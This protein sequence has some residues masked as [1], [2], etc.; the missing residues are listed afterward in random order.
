MSM[1]IAIKHNGNIYFGADSQRVMSRMKTYNFNESNYNVWKNEN[2]ENGLIASVGQKRDRDIVYTSNV[3]PEKITELTHK[4]VVRVFT[5]NIINELIEFKRIKPDDGIEMKSRFMIAQKDKL[6][7]VDFDG[8]VV[9]IDDFYAISDADEVAMGSLHTTV[10]QE[11]NE[12]IIQAFR[13]AAKTNIYVG[14][15][16][17]L[18]D[19]KDMKKKIIDF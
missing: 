13:A 8:A 19:T 17:L 16:I 11:P 1:I 9:E 5:Q 18:I 2:L 4:Y 6:F 7:V 14:F 12:R 3:I 15:P 10:G